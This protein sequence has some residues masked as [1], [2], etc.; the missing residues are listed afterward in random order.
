MVQPRRACHDR[1]ATLRGEG[2]P[3]GPGSGGGYSI[4][5]AEVTIQRLGASWVPGG[6]TY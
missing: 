3:Q 4:I 1:F 5:D 2:P 6:A